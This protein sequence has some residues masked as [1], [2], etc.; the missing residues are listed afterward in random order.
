MGNRRGNNPGGQRS[1]QILTEGL[2]FF[3]Y[4]ASVTAPSLF[5]AFPLVGCAMAHFLPALLVSKQG[6]CLAD[7]LLRQF[8]CDTR[9]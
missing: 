6:E 2:G 7:V 4:A 1:C 9:L 5:Q 3:T 8:R